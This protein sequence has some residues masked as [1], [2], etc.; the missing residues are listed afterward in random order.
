MEASPRKIITCSSPVSS[1]LKCKAT[2]GFFV[3]CLTLYAFAWLKMRNESSSQINQTGLG[4]GVRFE[5][6][7]VN[8]ITYWLFRCSFTARPN[9]D[10]RS[11]VFMRPPSSA[12]RPALP[13]PSLVLSHHPLWRHRLASS[14]KMGNRQPRCSLPSLWLP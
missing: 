9:F 4:C 13:H 6:T 10:V 11:T 7:V 14:Y 1:V 12:P 2:F 3:M 5:S 8:Q